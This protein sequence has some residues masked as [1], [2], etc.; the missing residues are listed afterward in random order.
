V[1]RLTTAADGDA[2]EILI[3]QPAGMAEDTKDPFDTQYNPFQHPLIWCLQ[4]FLAQQKAAGASSTATATS[5][6]LQDAFVKSQDLQ[7]AAEV[8]S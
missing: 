2:P 8:G 3:S 7:A 4:D 1:A 5:G 6:N